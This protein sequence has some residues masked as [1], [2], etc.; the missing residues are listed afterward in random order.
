MTIRPTASP[1]IVMSK[2]TLGLSGDRP[3]TIGVTLSS[4]CMYCMH[5]GRERER[6]SLLECAGLRLII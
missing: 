3:G 5:Y 2:N 4:V 6:E 1:P